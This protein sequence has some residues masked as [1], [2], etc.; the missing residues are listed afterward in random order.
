MEDLTMKSKATSYYL[1]Y[2]CNPRAE[3]ERGFTTGD[4]VIRAFAK[5][6]NI[7]W[8][9]AFDALVKA[10]RLFFTVPDCKE[11]FEVVFANYGFERKS[12][13]VAKGQSRMTVE[14]FCKT[15]RKG[16]YMLKVAHHLT[17]VVDG[18][19]FDTWNPADNCVYVYYE[20]KA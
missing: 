15:H 5:A 16:R 17:A 10:A 9:E 20:L 4:C 19:C 2:N 6:A 11:A 7:S 14:D 8:L 3:K 13:K 1:P 18:I 12:V